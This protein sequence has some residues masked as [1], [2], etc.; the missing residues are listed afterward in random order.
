MTLIIQE[1]S[2]GYP[3]FLEVLE[4][5]PSFTPPHNESDSWLTGLVKMQENCFI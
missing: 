3:V 5:C 2:I 1:I 4:L